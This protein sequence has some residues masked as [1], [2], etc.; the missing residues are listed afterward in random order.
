VCTTP[1]LRS[2]I[3]NV[4]QQQQHGNNVKVYADF[5]VKVYANFGDFRVSVFSLNLL[6]RLRETSWRT[7]AEIGGCKG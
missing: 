5:N 1:W 7:S 2:R 6:E 4:G 3:L